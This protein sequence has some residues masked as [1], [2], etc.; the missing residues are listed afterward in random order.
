VCGDPLALGQE[1]PS[2]LSG[3]DLAQQ[4]HNEHG[5]LK[6]VVFLVLAQR[7]QSIPETG[8]YHFEGT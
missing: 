6:T 5:V 3:I 8:E 2:W 4:A 1:T 7:S